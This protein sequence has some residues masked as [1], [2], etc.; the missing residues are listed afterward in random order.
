MKTCNKC[1]IEKPATLEYFNM[2]RKSLRADCRECRNLDRK[3]YYYKNH[4]KDLARVR[5]Y[6]KENP[7]IIRRQLAKR[8]AMKR[9]N[10]HEPY[11]EAQ[12]LQKYGVDCNICNLPIDLNAPRSSRF[13]GWENGLQFDHL[14]PLSKGGP[15]ILT[16]IRPTHGLCNNRKYNKEPY[17]KA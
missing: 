17:E 10:I 5:R 6:K 3:N 8:K 1:L 12:V 9:N 16:N 2:G 11:T 13:E 7:D 15:D 4:D 14:I